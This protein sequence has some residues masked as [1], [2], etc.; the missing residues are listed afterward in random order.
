MESRGKISLMDFKYPQLK[1]VLGQSRH[2]LVLGV[3]YTNLLLCATVE[4]FY[5]P[6]SV[7]SMCVGWDEW[8]SPH[9]D[10]SAP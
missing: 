1:S 8:D 7:G 10:T 5:V 6:G 9:T 4:E 2:A 3:A